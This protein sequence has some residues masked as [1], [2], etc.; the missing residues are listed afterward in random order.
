MSKVVKAVATVAAIGVLAFGS[1]FAGF[2]A[3]DLIATVLT[4]ASISF[5]AA[6]ANSILA[7]ALVKKPR[8]PGLQRDVS[9]NGAV[10]PQSFIMGHS[11]SAGHFA[12]PEST[13]GNAGKTPNAWLT[14]VLDMGD[15]PA[16]PI[17][18]LIVDGET[19]EVDWD[20][21]VGP[22]VGFNVL[23]R[24]NK[25]IW[26]QYYDGTQ[27]EA[28]SELLLTHG[29]RSDIPFTSDMVLTGVP[30][31]IVSFLFDR[32]FFKG[33]P[34][35]LAEG[36]AIPL[37]DPRLDSSV[38]GAGTQRWD[39]TSTWAESRNLALLAYNVR[40]GIPLP[41]GSIWGGGHAAEDLPLDVWLDAINECDALVDDGAG[42]TEPQWHGGMEVRVS[43]EPA[44]IE[45]EFLKGCLGRVA[46]AGGRILIKVGP[47]SPPVFAFTDDDIR[48]DAQV[49]DLPLPRPTEV[50]NGVA[51]QFPDPA[52][53]WEVRPAPTLIDAA[54]VAEDDGQERVAN[55]E[56][57]AV[58]FERQIQRLQRAWL[59]DS[60]RWRRHVVPLGSE[61]LKLEP[62][63][64][65][66]WTSPE[67][68]YDNKLFEVVTVEINPLST[69]VIVTLRETD[70][71]DFTPPA[72]FIPAPVTPVINPDPAPQGVPGYDF[73]A[74][75]FSDANGVARRPAFEHR[76][77]PD[78]LV[79][80][81][82]II[83]EMRVQATGELLPQ[84]QSADIASGVMKVASPAIIPGVTY[85]GR[86]TLVAPGRPTTPS[87]WVAAVAPPLQI[88]S[89]DLGDASVNDQHL[90]GF[91][92]SGNLVGNGSFNLGDARGW[93]A[94]PPTF[95]VVARAADGSGSAWDNIP[96]RFALRMQPDAAQLRQILFPISEEVSPGDVISLSVAHGST[97]GATS[98][99]RLRVQFRDEDDA[100][101]SA[102]LLN[103]AP[104]GPD[105][106]VT[107]VS[108]AAPAGAAR[109][110]GQIVR[111][112]GG[113]GDLFVTA[114]DV[115]RRLPGGRLV[116]SGG[117]DTELLAAR[118]VSDDVMFTSTDVFG[119]AGDGIPGI[120]GAAGRD[121]NVPIAADDTN[122]VVS[123]ATRITVSGAPEQWD[124]RIKVDG[125]TVVARA[126]TG[127]Q[128]LAS[129]EGVVAVDAGTSVVGVELGYNGAFLNG[130]VLVAKQRAR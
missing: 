14:Y 23:G 84:Q 51:A 44:A 56:V 18:R 66:T 77:D 37:Y 104:A 5:L 111:D 64:T 43:D 86:A 63:D 128:E 117:V 74:L 125:V 98:T 72:A 17:N 118:S 26:F 10:E 8:A 60:R 12:Y 87:A 109:M 61:A 21:P 34:R 71:G 7:K 40:R 57:P 59:N 124:V 112:A 95:S 45:A 96:T 107:A 82:S 76:W 92:R 68:G 100:F 38:G 108:G 89:A 126:G 41:D 25:K 30:F 32:D 1:P 39:D 123:L 69:V 15:V 103:A 11:A 91:S 36:A 42:G 13:W 3:A 46:D 48:R 85:E 130:F 52:S 129:F 122:L 24:F 67:R 33:F 110:R 53:Q 55:I 9:T 120:S 22:Q 79:D 93:T 80:V 31:M 115:R 81:T 101:I 113:A 70:A 75:D 4:T 73:V 88:S 105:W 2:A 20:G 28:A 29:D 114:V 83:G 121:F 119:G 27:T 35:V 78:E 99:V 127:P 102:L 58:P 62:F 47:P 97:A 19:V 54:L 90:V 49:E 16:G 94:L 106:T 50:W 65:V 116:T 6:Q